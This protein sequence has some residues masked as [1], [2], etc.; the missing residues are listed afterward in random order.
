MLNEQTPDFTDKPLHYA[1]DYFGRM[2][3]KTAITLYALWGAIIT[4]LK[5]L[6]SLELQWL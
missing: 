5:Q 6:G 4:L 3:I 1:L 2:M